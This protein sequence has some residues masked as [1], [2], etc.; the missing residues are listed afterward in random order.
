MNQTTLC[1]IEHDGK[2]L[3]L[4]RIK[5]KND[6]NQHKWI[7]VGG[8]FEE[9]ESPEECLLREVKEETGLTLLSWRFRGIIT[10]QSQGWGTEY[11]CLYTADRYAGCPSACNEGTLEWIPKEDVL[12]LNIWEGDKIFF[13]LLNENAPFFSMKLSYDGDRLVYASLDGKELELLDVVDENG[14]P[15]GVARERT[16]VHLNGDF[17]RTCHVW[18]VRRSQGGRWEVLLQKRSSRKE[19]YPGCYDCSA[20]GHVKAG[21]RCR[22]AAVRELEEE[23][24]IRAGEDELEEFG[25][26][27]ENSEHRHEGVLLKERELITLYLYLIPDQEPSVTLQE[28]EVESVLWVDLEDCFQIART[29]QLPNCLNESEL[30]ALKKQLE[31]VRLLSENPLSSERMNVV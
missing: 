18:A 12:K 31:I 28:E 4:H 9:G 30:E 21:G 23:L 2:Y 11:M 17:H 1:Y 8:H 20:A 26:I 27:R 3:M 14:N 7:G 13:R 5:K 29:G 15:T 10:F 16:L 25:E 6:V 22:E 19:T 24:G